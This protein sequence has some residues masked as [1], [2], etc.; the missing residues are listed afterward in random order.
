M[1]KTRKRKR[2]RAYVQRGC[3]IIP[4]GTGPKTCPLHLYGKYVKEPEKLAKR[5]V[6]GLNETERG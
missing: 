6:W 1:A 5:V 4:I 3:S 2:W